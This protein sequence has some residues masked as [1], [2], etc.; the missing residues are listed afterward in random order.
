MRTLSQMVAML[1]VHVRAAENLTWKAADYEN[2]L[3]E[4]AR[5]M[6]RNIAETP[7]ARCLRA[8]HDVALADDCIVHLPEDCLRIEEV[9]FQNRCGVYVQLTYQLDNAPRLPFCH[10]R[11]GW[12]DDGEERTIRIMEIR[13]GT[14]I[15]VVYFREPVF[16]FVDEGT[17]RNPDGAATAT[18]PGI[19]EMADSACEHLAA[20]LLLGEE[21]SDGTPMSYHGTQYNSMLSMMSRAAAV[22]PSRCYVKRAGGRL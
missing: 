19:P 14:A 11:P 7:A 21:T 12:T 10:C 2:A 3:E 6:W 22:R 1:K 18:Y 16:P 17:L 20:A 13:P 9:K 8:F 5:R 4:A 15:R